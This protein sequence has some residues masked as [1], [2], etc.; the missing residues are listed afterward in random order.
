MQR[1]DMALFAEDEW[2][3]TERFSLTTGARWVKDENYGD[4]FVPRLYGV[5]SATPNLTFKG[6][7][8]AGYRTPDLK[9]GDDHWIE[10]GG[11]P[12]CPDCRDV[13]NSD[14]QP[15]KSTTYELAALWQGDSGLQASATLFHT[16]Y[17]DK[18]DKPII[19]DTRDGVDASCLHLGEEYA[20]IYQYRNVDEAVV[21]GVELTL[22]TPITD[23]LDINAT[24]TFTDS[25]QQSGDNE[26]LPLNDQPRH[27]A[28]LGLDWQATPQTLLW[29][30][31]RYKG[32]TE[33]IG[34]RRGLSDSY[35]GYT[36]MDAG[37]RHQLNDRISLYGGI[38]NLLDKRIDQDD[39]DRVLDGR[40]FNAGINVRF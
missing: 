35:P 23:R 19:C 36:L 2:F 37:I 40:R 24:Y 25:E 7:V 32:D 34:G 14:L 30:K 1:W 29:S 16:D 27:R 17:E 28:S 20:A 22:N 3:L 39:Y 6:G 8:S 33:R 18:I 21:N 38:Y 11:G 15:E 5:Y 4:E 12:G 26:G 31:A 9:E 13:G 10:G